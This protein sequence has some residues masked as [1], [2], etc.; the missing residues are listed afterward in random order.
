MTLRSSP[1]VVSRAATVVSCWNEGKC[2][3]LEC[4][5]QGMT[6]RTHRW[7]CVVLE[8]GHP[9]AVLAR[10]VLSMTGQLLSH[11]ADNRF[12]HWACNSWVL[13]FH[14]FNPSPLR[15]CA[16]LFTHPLWVESTRADTACW[17]RRCTC[18]WTATIH[19]SWWRLGEWAIRAATCCRSAATESAFIDNK[20]TDRQTS[21][22]WT[23]LSEKMVCRVMFVPVFSERKARNCLLSSSAFLYSGE[24]MAWLKSS[25]AR[26]Q[27]ANTF[28]ICNN[29]FFEHVEMWYF[30]FS[31][32][33][34][35]GDQI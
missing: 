4:I 16:C 31:A 9:A 6:T 3:S 14:S 17:F 30:E 12:E 22:W 21:M 8:S 18:W 23:S 29:E 5:L 34:I 33:W 10:V 19:E 28:P 32:D 7:I 20:L 13:L 2:R 27:G 1:N 25:S 11:F 26:G 15:L 24:E 35:F